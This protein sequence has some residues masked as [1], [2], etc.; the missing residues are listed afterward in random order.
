MR[1]SKNSNELQARAPALRAWSSEQ[2]HSL[3]QH[4][5]RGGIIAYPT[6]SCFGLGCDP[7]NRSAV[8]KILRLKKRPQ[9]KGVILIAANFKQL[10]RY[11]APLSAA[12]LQQVHST[13]PGPHTWLLPK[14]E[15]CPI[16]LTGKHPKIAVRV[17]AH[18]PAAKLCRAAGMALVSTSANVSGAKAIRTTR[19]CLRQFGSQVLVVRGLVG[20]R[21][22]PSTIQDITTGKIF[23]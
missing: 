22:K 16:W 13:W 18:A 23:R 4:L 11:I 2:M 20:K 6:E 15:N 19:E 3:H 14:S 21:R 9:T 17:T 10:Q 1:A 12:Q 7:R 8:Q 5:N